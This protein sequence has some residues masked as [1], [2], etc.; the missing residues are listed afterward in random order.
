[1]P[2][3]VLRTFVYVDGFNFYHGCVR[4]TPYKWVDL[5]KLCSLILQPYNRIDRIRYFTA[6]VKGT[7][8]RDA[9]RRQRVFL[10]ALETLPEITIHY[11]MFLESRAMF[12]LAAQPDKRVRVIKTE[13]KGSDVNLASYLL[14]D[15]FHDSYDVAV[16][17]SNDS[18]LAEPIRMVKNEFE[19]PVVI[20][21]P[22][23][24]PGRRTS[25]EL[26]S[27]G[28]SNIHV[29]RQHLMKAQ[30]PDKIPG[31]DLTKP[32]PWRLTDGGD[33]PHPRRHR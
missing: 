26:K 16:V 27:I 23:S 18:D 33:G 21:Y 31:T 12:P 8:D 11:G 20:V 24:N 22:V 2:S 28:S 15:A 5:R 30:F 10:S 25:Q 7:T 32:K 17:V 6:L 9:P 4:H 3:K 13:E 14:L 29:R 1:M 19:K